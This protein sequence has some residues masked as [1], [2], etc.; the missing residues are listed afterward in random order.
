MKTIGIDPAPSAPSYLFDESVKAFDAIELSRIVKNLMAI[1]KILVCWDAPLT[2]P[3]D[4]DSERFFR[5]DHS[6]RDIEIFFT[7]SNWGFKTP[8][9]ISVL[10]YSGCQHWIITRKLLGLPRVSKWD[11][12]WD[13]LPF[14][15]IF[16]GKAPHKKGK[17]VVEVHPG[18]S[19]WLWFRK[20][21]KM[22]GGNWEYKK[23]ESV[24][25]KLWDR[26]L[27]QFGNIIINENRK[28]KDLNAPQN[29]GEL[30]AIV[31]WLLGNIWC[32]N[33]KD[34]ILLGSRKTGSMLLPNVEGLEKA[35]KIFIES[36]TGR[37]PI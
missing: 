27:S 2:G 14:K 11:K 12:E 6:Q 31:A 10:G 21:E 29:D 35:W 13:E 1:D 3:V 36:K 7:R 15:L 24:L 18:L 4:P 9:G 20:G 19:L 37:M 34:V 23:D 16:E 17:Y 8:K 32:S 25:K 33:Q 5:G 28:L 22:W 26:L 30:D